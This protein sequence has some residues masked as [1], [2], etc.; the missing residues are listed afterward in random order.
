MGV[1]SRMAATAATASRDPRIALVGIGV[2]TGAVLYAAVQT[3]ATVRDSVEVKPVPPK[4]QY[5]TQET[6]DALKMDTLDMLLRHPNDSVRAVASK[7]LCDRVINDEGGFETVLRGITQPDYETRTTSLRA[8]DFLIQQN[9]R[10]LPSHC[11][12]W[13]WKNAEGK[14]K[15]KE[16]KK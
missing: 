10:T 5:I 16:E 12:G 3:L 8:L 4:T 14:R 7:I 1:F 15:K 13:S 6:E 2:M 11:Q 9:T